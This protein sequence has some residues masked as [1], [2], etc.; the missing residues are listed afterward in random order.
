MQGLVNKKMDYMQ[1]EI[2]QKMVNFI[3]KDITKQFKKDQKM[4]NIDK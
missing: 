4:Y 3:N 2:E 1:D